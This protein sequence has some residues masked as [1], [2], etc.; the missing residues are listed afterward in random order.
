MSFKRYLIKTG[1]YATQLICT[2]GQNNRVF[3]RALKRNYGSSFA[4]LANATCR[5][6]NIHLAHLPR[7]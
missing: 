7:S 1:I 3:T 5:E 6:L 2:K 4:L